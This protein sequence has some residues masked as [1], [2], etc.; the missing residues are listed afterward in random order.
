MTSMG[1]SYGSG[2]ER[3]RDERR[4]ADDTVLV[5]DDE[6]DVDEV[7][8]AVDPLRRHPTF[9]D[10]GV[11][12]VD[13]VLHGDAPAGDE[14]ARAGPVGDDAIDE[15]EEGQSVHIDRGLAL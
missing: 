12:G 8:G 7:A 2:G 15:A 9:A 1:G 4:A 10:H 13:G 14:G 3:R 6:V 5:G 11:A